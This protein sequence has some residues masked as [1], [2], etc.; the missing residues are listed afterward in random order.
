MLIEKIDHIGIAVSDL[1]NALKL[2]TEILNLKV[3]KIEEFKDLQVKV[4]FIPI[5]GV[6]V[7]LVR[8]TSNDAPLAKRIEEHNEG[9][10]HLALRVDNIDEALERMKKMGVNMGDN[11]PRPGGMGSRIALSKPDSTNN[12]IIEFVERSQKGGKL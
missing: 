11:K 4:A 8:P 1:T 10:Y 3:M 5:G 6:L 7:E 12:V 9:L 2:Y